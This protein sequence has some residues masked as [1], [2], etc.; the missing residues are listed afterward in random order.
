MATYQLPS[1]DPMQCTGDVATNWRSF[2]E[3][4]TDYATAIELHKK[5]KTIQAATLKTV[6]GKECRQI[7]VRLELSEDD[8]KDPAVVVEKL[9]SYFEPSRNILYE[10][11]LFH[12]AK[13]QLNETVDQYI[14]RLRRLAETCNLQNLHDEMLR[15]RLVLGCKDKAAQA[16]LFRQKECDLKTALEALRICERTH[17]QLKQLATEEQE[18][19]L[20]ALRMD[21]QSR[22]RKLRN[23]PSTASCQ[24]CG[25]NHSTDRASCP[26]YGN[27]CN[28]CGKP[29]HFQ[30]VCRRRRSQLNKTAASLAAVDD[31]GV[32]TDSEESAFMVEEIGAVHH[33]WKGQYFAKLHFANE[34]AMVADCQLDMQCDHM[35]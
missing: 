5:E 19:P 8:A 26:A 28:H 15:D 27:T 20:H 31:G 33:N 24:Y 16:R 25:G 21:P 9:E 13:Q 14:I 30:A 35:P 18:T 12:A 34:G 3:A 1:P 29:N 6:M 2:K 22:K 23:T 10:R 7:I 4:Y 11:F 32:S 17:E